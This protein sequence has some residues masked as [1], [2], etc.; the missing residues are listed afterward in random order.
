MFFMQV[1]REFNH[2]NPQD[3]EE[4]KIFAN[5]RVTIIP[6]LLILSSVYLIFCNC[7]ILVSCNG[8]HLLSLS[9][10]AQPVWLITICRGLIIGSLLNV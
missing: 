1:L 3:D 7:L 6:C 4:G 8:K 10:A 2:V 5:T 9:R